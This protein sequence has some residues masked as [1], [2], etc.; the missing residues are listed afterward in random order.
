MSWYQPLLDYFSDHLVEAHSNVREYEQHQEYYLMEEHLHYEKWRHGE[1]ESI[2]CPF[3]DC[4]WK[5]EFV[6]N[7]DLITR[8]D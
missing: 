4:D 2:V 7:F 6:I 8:V 5:K 1:V 3:C